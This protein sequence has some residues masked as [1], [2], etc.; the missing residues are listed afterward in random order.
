MR[1]WHACPQIII[2]TSEFQIRTLLITFHLSGI[3]RPVTAMLAFALV[4]SG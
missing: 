3:K 4:S 1:L 2:K